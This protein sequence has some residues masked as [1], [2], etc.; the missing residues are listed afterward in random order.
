M[1]CRRSVG[2]GSAIG[3]FRLPVDLV[4]RLV[5]RLRDFAGGATDREISSGGGTGS[6]AFH[7]P[8]S[9]DVTAVLERSLMLVM[10][11]V[12]ECKGL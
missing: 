3:A 9:R 5:S 6:L 12:V 8:N 1:R 7:L 10:I 4:E 2:G 11:V